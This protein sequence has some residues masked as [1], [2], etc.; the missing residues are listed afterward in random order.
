MEDLNSHIHGLSV[1]QA[2]E[3]VEFFASESAGS[4]QES[5]P[6]EVLQWLLNCSDFAALKINTNMMAVVAREVAGRLGRRKSIYYQKAVAWRKEEINRH[7]KNF[8]QNLE[9]NKIAVTYDTFAKKVKDVNVEL[10]DQ[11]KLA[12]DQQELLKKLQKQVE[13]LLERAKTGQ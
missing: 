13:K 5:W 12:R 6:K 9:R 7:Y 2:V 1:S 8:F 10:E 11:K 4:L 3:A